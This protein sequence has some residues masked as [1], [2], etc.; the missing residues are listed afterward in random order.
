MLTTRA[1]HSIGVFSKSLKHQSSKS[2][3]S[4]NFQQRDPDLQQNVNG[5]IF[6]PVLQRLHQIP[7]LFKLLC[8]QTNEH[9][10]YFHQGF[11]IIIL[12]N[13]QF[14]KIFKYI[15]IYIGWWYF[16][17]DVVFITKFSMNSWDKK[18][19]KAFIRDWTLQNARRNCKTNIN[20]FKL[21]K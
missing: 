17:P 16:Y 9:E 1:E 4:C 2:L 8:W 12:C 10:T 14:R 11:T 13:S 19:L 20:N 15:F 21:R 5:F 7:K 18:I 3:L 6:L